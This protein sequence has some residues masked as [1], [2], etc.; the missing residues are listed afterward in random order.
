MCSCRLC[1][2]YWTANWSHSFEVEQKL[3]STR[4]SKNSENCSQRNPK[5]REQCYNKWINEKACTCVVRPCA[6]Q[7]RAS[8]PPKG[9]LL[10]NNSFH[11]RR[12]LF[13]L[14]R[15]TNIFYDP[16]L[17]N[18]IFICVLSCRFVLAVGRS[19]LFR[20]CIQ[21]VKWGEASMA[22]TRCQYAMGTRMR[23]LHGCRTYFIIFLRPLNHVLVHLSSVRFCIEISM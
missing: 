14:A 5:R 21:Q 16:S 13:G 4:D 1:A 15:R 22:D 11:L 17:S 23:R 2:E 20:Y 8:R 18:L 7:L 3:G 9:N 10:E 19:A 12:L 6:A